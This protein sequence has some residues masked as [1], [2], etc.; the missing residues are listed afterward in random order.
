MWWSKNPQVYLFYK[1]YNISVYSS[2][3]ARRIK[4]NKIQS[5]RQ[6]HRELYGPDGHVS[7]GKPSCVHLTHCCINATFQLSILRKLKQILILTRLHRGKS[8]FQRVCSVSV[9]ITV[10]SVFSQASLLLVL[11]L[12]MSQQ[13]GGGVLDPPPAPSW[14]VVKKSNLTNAARLEPVQSEAA[15]STLK[16]SRVASRSHMQLQGKHVVYEIIDNW[17]TLISFS[18][19][20]RSSSVT[21][22]GHENQME[23]DLQRTL[24]SHVM[25]I[26]LSSACFFQ[27]SRQML[28]CS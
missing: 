26:A 21:L 6:K 27:F 1:K 28:L 9:F 7:K 18:F 14:L 22:R 16:I 13:S 10:W 3:E 15:S 5:H 24:S 2:K 4:K 12:V 20:E 8:N 23:I 19:H 17:L 25:S 11:Y